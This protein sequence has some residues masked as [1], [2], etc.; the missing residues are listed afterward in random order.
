M[1]G[2]NISRDGFYK[3]E[4]SF[5]VS[6]SYGP[7]RYDPSY[8]VGGVDYPFGLVRWTENRNIEA[9]LDLML[10]GC[11]VCS[12]YISDRYTIDNAKDAYE[13]LGSNNNSHLGF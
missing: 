5:Q 13:S 8:E 1:A 7:G 6:C 11:L 2:T 9:C 10:Q 12:E 3:K 4:L